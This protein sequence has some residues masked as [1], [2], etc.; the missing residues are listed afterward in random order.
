[1]AISLPNASSSRTV[2]TSRARSTCPRTCPIA[3]PEKT[4]VTNSWNF[5]PYPDPR[6]RYIKVAVLRG[7]GTQN[8]HRASASQSF[9]NLFRTAAGPQ[10]GLPPPNPSQRLPRRSSGLAE[11]NRSLQSDNQLC[12]LDIGS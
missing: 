7:P 1:M 4:P 10:Q 9:I 6:P 11:L 2:L 12:V 8:T 3:A 5:Y